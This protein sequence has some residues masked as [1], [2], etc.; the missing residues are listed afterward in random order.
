MIKVQYIIDNNKS[1][2]TIVFDKKVLKFMNCK[3]D[4]YVFVYQSLHNVNH[5]V[6]IKADTGYRITRYPKQKKTY[7][8]NIGFRLNFIQEFAMQDCV[9]FM[10][11]NK[12]VRIKLRC[13]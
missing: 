13:L 4:D 11:K 9:Y 6:M 7:Q 3:V 10:K 2:L 1:L 12:S 8:L 5:I